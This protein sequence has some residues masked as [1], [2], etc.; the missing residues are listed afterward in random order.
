MVVGLVIYSLVALFLQFAL[1]LGSQS[2]YQERQLTVF[3]FV[4]PC[5]I[6]LGFMLYGS[7]L[8]FKKPI[9]VKS[10][11]IILCFVGILEIISVK[12]Q[13]DFFIWAI[14]TKFIIEIIP[15]FT[16]MIMTIYIFITL[17]K[18]IIKDKKHLKI[19]KI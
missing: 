2:P 19:V 10:A 7:I 14:G 12:M 11:W 3:N 9:A 5:F 18:R 6:T 1:S 4:I 8:L 15:I 13:V 16:G 17:I